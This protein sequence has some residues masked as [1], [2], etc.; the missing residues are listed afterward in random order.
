MQS[1]EFFFTGLCL[2]KNLSGILQQCHVKRYKNCEQLQKRRSL[3]AR[4]YQIAR[5]A[6][7]DY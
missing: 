6:V 5:N 7:Q 4:L 2:F 3:N 1:R